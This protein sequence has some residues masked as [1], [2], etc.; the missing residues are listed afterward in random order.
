M[1]RVNI[2]KWAG[3]ERIKKTVD[4]VEKTINDEIGFNVVRM[5]II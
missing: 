5:G 3:E 1:I 2:V 4:K